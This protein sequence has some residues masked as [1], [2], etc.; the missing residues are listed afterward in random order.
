MKVR[1]GR[2]FCGLGQRSDDRRL[3]G[4]RECEAGGCGGI[5]ERAVRPDSGE[6]SWDE[7]E[8]RR[9]RGKRP[10]SLLR[11]GDLYV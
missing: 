9:D 3:T 7:G 11:G 4:P 1:A 10:G 2:P 5:P 6:G 8:P